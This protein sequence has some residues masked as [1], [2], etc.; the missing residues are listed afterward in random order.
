MNH[1]QPSADAI[2][3]IEALKQ[4]QLSSAY[5]LLHGA[6]KHGDRNQNSLM[7]LA[8]AARS[9]KQFDVCSQSKSRRFRARKRK[10]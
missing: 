6:Y 7:G 9:Q 5:E 1:S 3:G 2:K 8:F 4:G 10:T